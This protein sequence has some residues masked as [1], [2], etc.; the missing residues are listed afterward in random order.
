MTTDRLESVKEHFTGLFAEPEY[1]GSYHDSSGFPTPLAEHASASFRALTD[2]ALVWTQVHGDFKNAVKRSM[3]VPYAHWPEL[4]GCCRD[5]VKSH[6]DIG[7]QWWG[8]LTAAKLMSDAM[9]L[10]RER[11]GVNAPRWWLPI[12]NRLRGR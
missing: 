12:I 9:T 8:P 1:D 3:F 4:Y 7:T 5:I 6:A 2:G 10:L 11:H